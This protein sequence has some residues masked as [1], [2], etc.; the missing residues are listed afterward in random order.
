MP[1]DWLE[2]RVSF[3]RW[4]RPQCPSSEISYLRLVCTF[5]TQTQALTMTKWTLSFFPSA[6]NVKLIYSS[7]QPCLL[8]S[9]TRSGQPPP[10]LPLHQSTACQSAAVIPAP[11][12]CIHIRTS[13]RTAPLP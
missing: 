2:T 7:Y 4:K 5:K 6:H 1:P 13:S 12:A 8:A 9:L 11:V 10:F 3:E